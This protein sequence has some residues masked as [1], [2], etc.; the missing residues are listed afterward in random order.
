MVLP[1]I[2]GAVILIGGAVLWKS[3]DTISPAIYRIFTS[4]E[5]QSLDIKKEEQNFTVSKRGLFNNAY[6]FVFGESAYA[7]TFNDK[8]PAQKTL[9][10]E[11]K[12]TP[13]EHRSNRFTNRKASRFT[14]G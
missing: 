7:Q 1:L 10:G 4:K 9:T 6:A 8:A 5:K 13:V 14:D 3:S 2:I 11:T 12:Q